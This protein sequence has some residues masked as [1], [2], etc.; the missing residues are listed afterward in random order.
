[1]KIIDIVVATARAIGKSSF[2]TFLLLLTV[3]MLQL[4]RCES[5][6]DT[7]E[8]LR[9]ER[10]VSTEKMHI[11]SEEIISNQNNLINRQDIITERQDSLFRNQERILRLK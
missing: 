9:Q 11:V 2:I 8:L 7:E 10:L 1:M 6:K 4:Q 3:I 5:D